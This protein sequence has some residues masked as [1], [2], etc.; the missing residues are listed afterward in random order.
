M[1]KQFRVRNFKNFN[2]E[3]VFNLTNNRDYGWNESLVKDGLINK[4]IIYGENNSG[5]SNL[6]AAIMDIT[7]HLS[8]NFHINRL[9][10]H[11]SN[12][13]SID[14]DVSFNYEFVFGKINLHYRYRKDKTRHLL[15]EELICDNNVLFKY[16]YTNNKYENRIT[17]A[18]DIDLSKRNKI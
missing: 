18:T 7:T 8:D 2:E 14:N 4:A 12:G 9:Y 10:N 13:N 11:Y 17:G 16:N 5:K 6:G 3:I 15:E 1:I